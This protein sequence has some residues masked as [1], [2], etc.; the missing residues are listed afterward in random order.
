MRSRQW[1]SRLGWT[2]SSPVPMTRCNDLPWRTRTW[3]MTEI[4]QASVPRP[5]KRS[6]ATSRPEPYDSAGL[7]RS[8]QRRTVSM[9]RF[10]PSAGPSAPRC[11]A[12]DDLPRGRLGHRVRVPGSAAA[13][14]APPARGSYLRRLAET[15]MSSAASHDETLAPAGKQRVRPRQQT[16]ARDDGGGAGQPSLITTASRD[17][18]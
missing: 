10:S 4:M 17:E 8:Q 5:W 1:A 11:L 12:D 3:R 9:S 14:M 16:P 13:E 2:A 18:R 6:G 7:E 15:G